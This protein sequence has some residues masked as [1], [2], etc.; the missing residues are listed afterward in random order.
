MNKPMFV[1]FP[2]L[3]VHW[4]LESNT[5][6]G[7]WVPPTALFKV[8]LQQSSALSTANAQQDSLS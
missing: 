7:T 5:W 1:I 8:L 3:E 4:T 2:E 6:D